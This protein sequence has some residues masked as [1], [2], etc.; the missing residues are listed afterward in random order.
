VGPR[1]ARR[2]A[3]CAWLRSRLR[4]LMPPP[5]RLWRT[6]DVQRPKWASISHGAPSRVIDTEPVTTCRRS[7]YFLPRSCLARA[8]AKSWN[9]AAPPCRMLAQIAR[10]PTGLPCLRHEG[11]NEHVCAGRDLAAERQHLPSRSLARSW[12]NRHSKP[13]GFFSRCWRTLAR[14]PPH[15]PPPAER[16]LGHQRAWK[17]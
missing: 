2:F 15:P 17:G 16:Y 10:A 5:S 12:T 4:R 6:K 1:H 11:A 14:D 13:G 8:A 9:L 7:R 3:V